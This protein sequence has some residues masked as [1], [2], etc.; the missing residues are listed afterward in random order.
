MQPT[1]TARKPARIEWIDI[2][3]GLGII[4]VSFGHLRNG[5]GEAVWLPALDSAIDIIYLFHMPLFFIL[6]GVTFSPRGGF[7]SFTRRK[8]KTLILPYYVFSLYFIA[9]PLAV[10]LFP[11]LADALRTAHDYGDARTQLFDVVIMGNG[12][13]FLMALFV[14]EL[15]CF[16]VLNALGR[17]A[18]PAKISATALAG[19]TLIAG[20][21]LSKDGVLPSPTLPFQLV[22]GIQAGGFLLIGYACRNSLLSP[23]PVLSCLVS[24]LRF[25]L[26]PVGSC[27]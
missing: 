18:A 1:A 4:L 6:A 14:G 23:P 27:N 3:R 10:L 7:V 11:F 22:P 17:L 5:D 12:L 9:K 25:G 20:V 26:L 19:M 2:A 13:W 15:V 21:Y 24:R 8:L 16:A